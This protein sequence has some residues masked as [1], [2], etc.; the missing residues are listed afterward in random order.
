MVARLNIRVCDC[1]MCGTHRMVGFDV[2]TRFVLFLALCSFCIFWHDTLRKTTV[3][4]GMIST[5][6]Q[7]F[8]TLVERKQGLQRTQKCIFWLMV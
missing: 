2:S 4:S 5:P 3:P 8:L 6:N 1:D 7:A